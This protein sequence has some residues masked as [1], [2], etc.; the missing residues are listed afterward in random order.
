M[1]QLGTRVR[2]NL[3]GFE[4]IAVGRTEWQ[5]GCTRI[6]IEPT[7]LRDGKPIDV[8]WFDEQRVEAVGEKAKAEPSAARPPLGGPQSDPARSSARP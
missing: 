2:D 7:E 3:T 8:Q 1:I 5:Y 4:G 6:G